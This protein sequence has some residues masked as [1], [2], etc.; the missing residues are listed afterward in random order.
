MTSRRP[1]RGHTHLTTRDSGLWV[2]ASRQ[3]STGS[4]CSLKTEVSRSRSP[5]SP[6]PL[7]TW[8]TSRTFARRRCRTIRSG[9]WKSSCVSF[10]ISGQS[11]GSSVMQRTWP[12]SRSITIVRPSICGVTFSPVKRSI[13]ESGGPKFSILCHAA[14][15]DLLS[16]RLTIIINLFPE[17]W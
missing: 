2:L 5:R 10:R 1:S 17:G 16:L 6:N 4:A 12:G 13:H 14:L 7:T 9:T 15:P 3:N 8:N 11:S